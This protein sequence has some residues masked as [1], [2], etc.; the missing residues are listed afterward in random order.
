MKIA[1]AQMLVEPG[2]KQANLRRAEQRIAE[3]ARRGAEIVVLPEA[4]TL[5]WTHPSAR[6]EADEIPEGES[7]ARLCAAA[8]GHRIF[9]C[10]GL[11]ERAGERIFNA[12]V[13]AAP[14]GGVILHHRKIHEL[15][16][17]HDLYALGDRLAVAETKWG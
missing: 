2:M 6:T 7:C 5:G 13:I 16:I 8:R 14:N 11:V 15:D 17:A 12:A 10:A 1:L 4:L 9:V 3:A